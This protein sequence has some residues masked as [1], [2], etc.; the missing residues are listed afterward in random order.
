MAAQRYPIRSR[1]P[2]T[3]SSFR[4]VSIGR[5]LT[6]ILTVIILGLAR[7]VLAHAELEAA[8]PPFGAQLVEPPAEIRLTF[9]EPLHEGSTFSLFGEGFLAIAGL[10]VHIN[11]E[12]PQELMST[13]P[14]LE[15]GLY[16][17]QWTA[18][19]SDGH[20]STGSYNFTILPFTAEQEELSALETAAIALVAL[21]VLT[22]GLWPLFRRK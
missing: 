5:C 20:S 3:F 2:V 7:P 11:P 10:A 19:G 18:A 12:V 4:R 14:P 6:F 21:G 22:L 17:I 15:P 1:Q 13:V 16:T 8:D 9:S